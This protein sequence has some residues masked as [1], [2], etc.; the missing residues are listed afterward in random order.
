MV[1]NSCE[2][3]SPAVFALSSRSALRRSTCDPPTSLVRAAS[4]SEIGPTE[5]TLSNTP[6][7]LDTTTSVV[8][9]CAFVTFDPLNRLSIVP[10][11]TSTPTGRVNPPAPPPERTGTYPTSPTSS[12]TWRTRSDF[13]PP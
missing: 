10:F 13:D 4:S 12:T 8:G 2:N 7:L 3:E 9:G 5:P 6:P 11:G 1:E